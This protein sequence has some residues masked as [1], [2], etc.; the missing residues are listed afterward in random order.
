VGVEMPLDAHPPTVDAAAFD[1]K[2]A[3]AERAAH[4]DLPY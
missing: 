1:E 3:C 4:V 2:L